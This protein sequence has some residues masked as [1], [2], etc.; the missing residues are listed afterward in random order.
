[1]I[2]QILRHMDAKTPE[3]RAWWRYYEGDHPL[4]FSTKKLADYWDI[5]DAPFVENWVS[6][7]ANAV[8]DRLVLTG[9][10]VADNEPANDALSE[11]FDA[12]QWSTLASEVHQSVVVT[13]EGFAISQIDDTDQRGDV[14]TY[15]Q[16][17][18]NCAA[19]YDPAHPRRMLC[20]AKRLYDET[21]AEPVWRLYIYYP[22]RTEKYTGT[23]NAKSFKDFTL[24]ED[25]VIGNPYGTIPVFHFRNDARRPRPDF[26]SVIPLQDAVNKQFADLMVVSDTT[27]FPLR[28]LISA[29]DV[30]LPKLRPGDF[31]N[32]PGAAGDEQQTVV[33]SFAAANL[34]VYTESKSD[35]AHAIASISRTPRHYFTGADGQPSGEA[36]QAMEA[37][38]VKKV[39][40]Y[41]A[42]LSNTWEHAAAYA[43][44]LKGVV[45]DPA[46]IAATW[47]DPRTVQ[48][49]SQA[50]ARATNVQ[51]GIPIMTLLRDEGWRD[52]ELDQMA[53]DAQMQKG[54]AEAMPLDA[55]A[56]D[57]QTAVA[58]ANLA[59][60][61]ESVVQMIGDVALAKI[62]EGDRLD[63]II[64]T[65][66]A[67]IAPN[68]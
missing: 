25:G 44:R 8:I 46:D 27:A 17:A 34:N 12:G 67:E 65:K 64:A 24:D 23:K 50:Q 43:L 36:L 54:P 11:I 26:E 7:V 62:L 3:H 41:M 53:E 9:F 68:G 56:T 16:V 51:A 40:A 59:P 57:A 37:P 52:S 14:E 45:V 31:V 35:L 42:R 10:T 28:Y 4:K 15:S 49:I 63:R 22:D 32:I 55:A 38:L 18:A 13:G 60:V 1:M 39:K 29:A 6:V 2:D 19:V 66:Q 47:D 21:G 20:A 58:A 33:G 48:T 5:R 30:K 61:V